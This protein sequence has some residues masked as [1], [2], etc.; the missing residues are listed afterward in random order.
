MKTSSQIMIVTCA[1]VSALSVSAAV[2]KKAPP[3]AA[4]K[5]MSVDSLLRLETEDRVH[6]LKARGPKVYRDLRAA[7]F[8]SEKPYEIRWRALISMAWLGGKESI[9]D[10]EKAIE[11]SDWFMRDAALKG[12]E[13]VNKTKA[14][15]WGKRLMN[16]PALVVRTAAVRVLHDLNDSTSEGLLWEKLNAPENFR[17]EQSL[18]IRRQIVTALSDLA[19]K[20]SEMKFAALL[21][22]KDK[23]VYGPAMRGLE[24]LTG[25]TMDEDPKKALVLWKKHLA[26]DGVNKKASQIH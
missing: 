8:N 9:V 6:A 19:S 15:Y 3:P 20:G 26:I 24:R 18:W 5:P 14:I 12:L 1:L 23:S 21:E 7:A 16:D 17:G 4:K 25:R 22:D 10:L 2:S 11:S 13:K